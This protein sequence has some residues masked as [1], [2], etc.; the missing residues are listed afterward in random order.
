MAVR[1]QHSTRFDAVV[2]GGGHNGLVA[3]GMLARA[4]LSVMVLERLPRLGG[5]AISEAPFAGVEARLS[6]YSYLVSLLPRAVI[7]ALGLRVALRPR[8]VAAYSPQGRSGLLLSG[9]ADVTR[10]SM[11]RITADSRA[12]VAWQ[13]FHEMLARVARRLFPTLTEPLRSREHMRQVIGDDA[14]W[15]ALFEEPLGLMLERAFSSDLLR[16]VVCTDATIGTFAP[17]DD[18]LLRQNR[19]F[20][21]HV[22]GN[23]TGRWDVP[24]GGMGALSEALGE[25]SPRERRIINDRRLR[26]VADTKNQA[27]QLAYAKGKPNFP[28]IYWD[29]PALRY[30]PVSGRA[31]VATGIEVVPTPGHAP[32]HQSLVLDL[33][34]T[35]RIVLCGDAA[36]TRENLERGDATAQDRA[37]AKSS[38]AL[39]RSLVRDD[40]DLP[41]ARPLLRAPVEGEPA[42]HP[43]MEGHPRAP[44]E[45]QPQMF[46]PAPHR[47]HAAAAQR[48]RH[49][50][51]AGLLF[52][53]LA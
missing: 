14:A 4:G 9:Q 36:F 44:V 47:A 37:A 19:C 45:L 32:G 26:E 50:L 53:E 30:V 41:V 10:E 39:I 34:E 33:P 3:A 5:A 35:G 31:K 11:S 27:E 49:E 40:L 38:L 43:E 48:R 51:A 24:V 29:D 18:S 7:G 8:A 25:L 42:G 46:A 15:Q 16:G 21:Y 17:A 13:R 20:L 23:G 2:I 22:I 12:F 6:R 1:T 28:A 52:R